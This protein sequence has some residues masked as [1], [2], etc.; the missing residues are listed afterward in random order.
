MVTVKTAASTR[1]IRI[2][3]ERGRNNGAHKTVRG[4]LFGKGR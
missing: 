1:R 2:F 3:A 4:N